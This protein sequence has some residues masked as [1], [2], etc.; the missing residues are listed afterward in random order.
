MAGRM[1]AATAGALPAALRS[2]GSQPFSQDQP[3][4][5]IRSVSTIDNTMEVV[6]GK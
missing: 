5:R 3:K 1:R 4:N 6:I 2:L